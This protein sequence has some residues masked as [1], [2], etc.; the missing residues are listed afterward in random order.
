[1]E[2]KRRHSFYKI[3]IRKNSFVFVY[4][5]KDIVFDKIIQFSVLEE[6]IIF[7]LVEN[8]LLPQV[9]PCLSLSLLSLW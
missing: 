8:E 9:T 2:S 7:A 3:G 6:K 4:I 1:M 5:A